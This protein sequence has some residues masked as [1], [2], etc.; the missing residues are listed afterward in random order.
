M[1]NSNYLHR[2]QSEVGFQRKCHLLSCLSVR[3][4][5]ISQR[6]REDVIGAL[7][8]GWIGSEGDRILTYICHRA[9]PGIF[10][11]FTLAHSFPYVHCP[12]YLRFSR[13]VFSGIFISSHVRVYT[14]KFERDQLCVQV[15]TL[16]SL[17]LETF[18]SSCI[19]PILQLS[20]LLLTSHSLFSS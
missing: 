1:P 8:V 3:I 14:E 6:H 7:E 20:F 2:G 17:F 13:L 12:A 11:L 16:F 18:V 9:R 10:H 4:F 5:L 19:Q 15:R